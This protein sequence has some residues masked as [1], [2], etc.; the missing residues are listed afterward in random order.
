MSRR[1]MR[2]AS[3]Q[4]HSPAPIPLLRPVEPHL[5][6]S[7]KTHPSPPSLADTENRVRVHPE[8]LIVPTTTP[9]ADTI[10]AKVEEKFRDQPDVVAEHMNALN[11][12]SFWT[13]HCTIQ[14]L[15]RIESKESIIRVIS[16]F[17]FISKKSVFLFS[18]Y[19]RKIIANS[20]QY[21]ASQLAQII[22]AFAQL[23]FLEESFCMQLN[24]RLI[25]DMH[26]VSNREFVHIADGFASTR[27]YQ[28]RMVETFL[29]HAVDRIP[30]MDFYEVSLFLSSLARLNVRNESVFSSLG[31]QFLR[32]IEIDPAFTARDL[33]LTAYA[34]SKMNVKHVPE[35]DRQLVN[36]S[37]SVI[38]DFTAKELQMITTAFNKVC[39]EDSELFASISAQAQRRIAQFS[40]EALVHLLTALLERKALDDELMSRMVCQLPRLANSMH[41]NEMV[42]L[43]TVFR[44]ASFRSFAAMEALRAPLVSKS[45]LIAPSDWVSILDCLAKIGSVDIF[46]E[47]TDAFVL[48]NSSPAHYRNTTSLVS[49]TV[50]Q[51]M[52]LNQL[53]SVLCSVRSTHDAAQIVLNEIAGRSLTSAEASEVYCSLVELNFHQEV[54]VEKLMRGLLNKA[55]SL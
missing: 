2:I 20:F 55:I 5:S 29:T 46:S 44:D 8:W 41:I 52:S 10:K 7:F 25:Q 53:T 15:A 26:S 47:M 19:C 54:P 9:I 30:E 23:G 13:K 45:G 34:F 49:S 51:R 4:L 31:N 17:Q 18:N 6:S 14:D 27:C 33:T 24:E 12:D 11:C 21:S 43:L 3:K 40:S 28:S 48:V 1:S 32:C 36:L 38:R 50:L 35:L 16:T 42:Q 39:V 37:K 22:H